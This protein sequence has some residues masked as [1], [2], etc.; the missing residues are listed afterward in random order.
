M[1]NAFTPNTLAWFEVATDDPDTATSFYADLFGWTFQE[2]PDSG[3]YRVITNGERSNGGIFPNPDVPQPAWLPYFGIEDLDGL[4]T[5][6]DG[7]GGRLFNG[8]VTVPAGRFAVLA[9]PQGAMVA[10][11]TGDYDD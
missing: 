4:L 9:D 6:L 1:T 8:P 3:G 2:M 7:L 10:V 5:R 11:L